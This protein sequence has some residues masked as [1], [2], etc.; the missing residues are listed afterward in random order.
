MS[1]VG[2]VGALLA[3]GLLIVVHELGHFLAAKWLGVR[4]ERFAVG[5]GPAL[6]RWQWGQTEY[7]LGAVPLGGYVKMA[8]EE[9]QSAR[10]GA[11]DEFFGQSPGRRALIIVAGVVMNAL[12][13][14]ASFVIAFQIGVKFPKAEVGRVVPGGPAEEAGLKSGDEITGVG[15][16]RNVDFYDLSQLIAL[17]DPATGVELTIR[18]DGREQR[19]RLR[20]RYSP[21]LGVPV[22]GF[23]PAMS[24]TI[25][26]LIKDF[27]AEQ[28]GLR[29]G[30]RVVA[31]GGEPM[32]SW[33]HLY[34]TVQQSG[35]SELAITVRREEETLT[36]RVS[37][38]STYTYRLGAWPEESDPV[39]QMVSTLSPAERA[40]LAVGDRIVAVEGHRIQSWSQLRRML[41]EA[42]PGPL[43]LTVER[44]DRLRS[45]TVVV[46]AETWQWYGRI[47][48]LGAPAV[49][50]GVEPGGPAEA[51]G[52]RPGMQVTHFVLSDG[53]L[54]Q[55][56]YWEELEAQANGLYGLPL[57]L[58]GLADG[59][60]TE[61]TLTP[62]RGES[63]G[64]VLIGI[65]PEPK[66]VVR[67]AGFLG[68]SKL[69]LKKSVL[70]ALS[71]YQ[72]LRRLLFT[73][74]ISSG[75]LAGPLTIGYITYKAAARADLS[76]LLYFLGVVGINL[77]LVNLFPIPILDGGHLMVIG[78]EKLKGSPVSPRA[79]AVA[80]YVGLAL[81][82]GLFLFV[83]YNDIT[84]NLKF[85][86]GG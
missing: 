43:Q 6:V 42:E 8:G 33:N 18:R 36:F 65:E 9:S 77:A 47:G 52:L 39:V 54:R 32:H 53:S 15:G 13:A 58:R 48:L 4:V 19:L 25:K 73:R 57:V 41:E 64:R 71:V 7:V 1:I 17:S 80:Q 24:L 12:V 66:M 60:T 26:A 2:V 27:P 81:I 50:G 14:L 45:V 59:E 69:G 3:V 29:P 30:D 62:V 35:G 74:S 67:K 20:P 83:T 38:R 31:V 22:P 86:L 76:R 63:A 68:A 55:V 46:P 75:Q 70:T 37:P 16:W 11:P 23:D 72:F 61:V 44:A 78:V 28:A 40:G 5:F 56:S 10:R 51:A 79:L 49:V 82:L 34:Q 21:A 84:R 85:L